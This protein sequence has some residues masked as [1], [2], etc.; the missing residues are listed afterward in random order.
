MNNSTSLGIS[1]KT[2]QSGIFNILVVE[3]EDT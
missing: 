2:I 1:N 3:N